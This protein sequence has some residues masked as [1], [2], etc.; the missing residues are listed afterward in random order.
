[1]DSSEYIGSGGKALCERFYLCN[2]CFSLKCESFFR[3]WR[4]FKCSRH[5]PTLT[6]PEGSF[7]FSQEPATGHIVNQLNLVRKLE[8]KFSE[9]YFIWS[10][11]ICLSIPTCIFPSDLPTKIL[12]AY[13]FSAVRFHCAAYHTIL[14]IF[15]TE[16]KSQSSSLCSLLQPPSQVQIFSSTPCSQTP[17]VSEINS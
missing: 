3:R 7:P 15:G 2:A 4:T 14:T 1:M 17:S 5:F 6:E 16:H 9:I 8:T 11:Y 12:Y 10:S 13:F